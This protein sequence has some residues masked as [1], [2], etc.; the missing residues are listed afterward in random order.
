MKIFVT[1]GTG[2]IGGY[3]VRRLSKIEHQMVCLV[4]KSSDIHVVKDIDAK[5][6]I[7]DLLDKASLIEG[8][9]GCDWVVNLASNFVFWVPNKH[10]YQEVNIQGTQNIMESAL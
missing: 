10:V 8:M 2:F 5:I 3:L 1:G 9:Q 4:R 7:G 6:V